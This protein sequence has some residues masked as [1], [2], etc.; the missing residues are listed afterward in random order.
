MRPGRSESRPQIDSS[1]IMD[2]ARQ[3]LAP[4]AAGLL[5]RSSLILYGSETGN[6]QDVAEE[7]SKIV[8]RLHFK[9]RVEEMNTVS[10]VQQPNPALPIVKLTQCPKNELLQHTC[11]ILVISTP[12][13]GDMPQNSGLFWRSLL[14]KKLPPAC[15]ATMSFTTFGLGDSSYPK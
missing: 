15:L 6:S 1:L 11:V 10:L 5:G 12:G 4:G 9:S 13:Q 8:Q 2:S 3:I 14:R 7:L